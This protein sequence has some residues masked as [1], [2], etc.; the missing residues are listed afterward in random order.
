MATTT[1]D[2]EDTEPGADLLGPWLIGPTDYQLKGFELTARAFEDEGLAAA[3]VVMPTGTGKTILMHMLARWIIE[4]LGGRV[5]VL[6]HTGTLIEQTVNKAGLLGLDRVVA[7]ERADQHARPDFTMR[8]GPSMFGGGEVDPKLVVATVQTLR[9]RRLRAWPPG[10]FDLVIIDEAHRAE[11]GTYKDILAHLQPR[12]TLGLTATPDRGDGKAIVGKNQ[13][14]ERCTFEYFMH[15]AVR[16]GHLKRPIAKVLDTTIDLRKLRPEPGKDYN[17]YEV[18]QLLLPHVSDICNELKG[19]LAG[20]RAVIFTPMVVSAD[21]VASGL[22]SCGL[23]AVSVSGKDGDEEQARILAEFRGGRYQHVVNAN[24]LTEGWDESFVDT[25]VILRLTKSRAFYAQMVGR[26]LRKHEGKPDGYIWGLNWQ[27]HG[28]ELVRPVEIFD[29]PTLKIHPEILDGAQ[30]L[31]DSG[32]EVDLSAAL[33]RAQAERKERNRVQIQ[34]RQRAA[35]ATEHTYDMLGVGPVEQTA[36]APAMRND[37]PA[38]DRQVEALIK[39]GIP[40]ETAVNWSKKRA[41]GFIGKERERK[42]EGLSSYKQQA[43][44]RKLGYGGVASKLGR[45]EAKAE[46]DKLKSSRWSA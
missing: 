39:F 37:P 2:A 33:K 29:S 45:D 11:G 24:L 30:K 44:L 32:E 9:G 38:T 36:D 23:S 14:F 27:T 10:H 20:R 43:Y 4:D 21:A 5:L 35:K 15:D 8:R 26:A 41:S 25:A 22:V 40:P 34:V 19:R 16:G 17:D 7:T 28:H 6:A 42:A 46:I 3:L 13:V 1:A 31:V 18:E 12:W